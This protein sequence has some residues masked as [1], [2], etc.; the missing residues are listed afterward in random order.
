MSTI[1]FSVP[2]DVKE[3]FNATFAGQNKS[4][5]LAQLLREAVAQANGA[6][7]SIAPPQIA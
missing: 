7:Q 1:D 2:E 6:H 4:A 3:A 5:I